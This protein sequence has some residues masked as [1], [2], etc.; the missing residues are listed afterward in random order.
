MTAVWAPCALR[1][2]ESSLQTDKLNLQTCL[3][4]SLEDT[5]V[6]QERLKIQKTVDFKILSWGGGKGER[7]RRN[8]P[9][10]ESLQIS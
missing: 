1:E 3:F 2:E 8:L 7:K 5:P 6:M 9:C 4:C 10:D